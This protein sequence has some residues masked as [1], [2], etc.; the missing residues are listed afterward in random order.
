MTPRLVEV[1]VPKWPAVDACENFKTDFSEPKLKQQR[2]RHKE[3]EISEFQTGHNDLGPMHG[4]IPTCHS[5]TVSKN[6]MYTEKAGEVHRDQPSPV[7]EVVTTASHERS[8]TGS[9]KCRR[10]RRLGPSGVQRHPSRPQ[11]S[12]SKYTRHSHATTHHNRNRHRANEVVQREG[13][14]V[15]VEGMNS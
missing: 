4:G 3:S 8:E 11:V 14:N 7:R 10:K 2:G 5:V 6:A 1:F 12:L 9:E 15:V 13:R